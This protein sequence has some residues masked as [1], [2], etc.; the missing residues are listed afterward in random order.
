MYESLKLSIQSLQK[1]KYG[2]GNKKKLSAI[3]HALNRAN[4]IF[5]LDKQNQ[6][7]PESIKQISF[8]NVSSEEQVPRILDEFMDDFEKE[9]LEKDNG[10]A[11][12]YS[13]FSVTSYKIIRTLD[14]GKRRGL[15]SAHALNRLNKMFVKHPV[16]Y[17]K[18]AIRDPLGLAF[19]ITELAIDI[20][21]NLSIP[22]EFD[23]TI[24]DQMMPLLQRY[25]VQYDDTVRTI[26][27]EFSSMP[28]FKLVIE[29]GEKH[30]ELIEKFLDYSIARLPLETR[31]KKAKSIL[32]KIIAEEVDSVALGYYE[33]L[34]LTFS[35]ET[36]RPH[37]SKI[38]KEMP[39]TNR[40]F[41]NTILEEVS[42][43]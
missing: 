2:K 30:K 35:D 9:C 34:K 8:R 22:Y 16:K 20:E 21:K 26:L 41:A 27:E 1:S 11:K 29:I 3:M 32:E 4:S 37:L 6:T 28:K 42:A 23:Q 18:Q 33:N 31:I 15:L 38:A 25:Y 7:N 10:N 40:R 39:K 43:L 13:L 24:L 17:S 19:V 36:L 14:S 12:N 5:N